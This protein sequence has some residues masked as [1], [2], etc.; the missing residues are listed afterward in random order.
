MFSKLAVLMPMMASAFRYNELKPGRCPHR[1]GDIETAKFAAGDIE[2]LWLN[3]FDRKALNEEIKCYSA[4][5]NGF[6]PDDYEEF[7]VEEKKR[8]PPT[9]FEYLSLS[10]E[11]PEEGAEQR[12]WNY[13][14]GASLNFSFHPSGS[15]GILEHTAINPSGLKNAQ[16]KYEGSEEYD[17]HL[18]D[19]QYLRYVQVL[20]SDSKNYLVV[21]KCLE[22]AKYTDTK[23][24]GSLSDEEA[25]KR[26]TVSSMDFT[27]RPIVEYKNDGTMT[28]QPMHF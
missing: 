26:S 1:P 13:R 19:S 11:R 28:L 17:P 5:F 22:T 23:T 24:G 15:V 16:E 10:E 9:F 3:V 4:R 25:W 27:K 12:Y 21:Y 20:D 14:S 6:S 2:G 18:W 7:E 8:A